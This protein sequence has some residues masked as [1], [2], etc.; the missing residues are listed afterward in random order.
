MIDTEHSSSFGAVLVVGGCGYLGRRI[1]LALLESQKA[2][3]VSVIDIRTDTNQLPN[4]SYYTADI[5]SA[6][7]VQSVFYKVRP[8][9][10]IH[11]ASPT[12]FSHNM[13]FFE[14]IN[15]GGTRNLLEASKEVQSV[16][17][18]VYTSSASV[19]HDSVSDLFDG[20]D[21]LPLLFMPQQKSDYSHTKA[22]AE[23]LVL[24]ANRVN[25]SLLTVSLRPS[26]MFGEDDPTTVKPMVDAAAGGKYRFQ[27]GNGKNLFEWTYVGNVVDAHILAVQT[28]LETHRKKLSHIPAENRVDGEAF[29]ITN[30]DA[31]PFW[32]FAR[33]IGAAAGYPTKK[34]EVI[35]IPRLVGLVIAALAEWF[36]W[37]FS[38]GTKKPSM[39]MTGIRFSTIHRTFRI[40]KAK[41]RL[42]YKPRVNMSEAISR[43]GES[44]STKK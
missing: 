4:V 2:S 43:A 34:T 22:M 32:D 28:L 37:L 41:D 21:T 31:M 40:D 26:G 25:G 16:K 39:T 23:K 35:A 29:L 6:D 3:S 33:A 13:G 30:D 20:D 36:V 24:Q 7:H 14:K 12:A 1:V 15:I 9:V 10:V 27:I 38:F 5:S 42:G 17:V 18:F 11:T 19:V 44:F 8:A